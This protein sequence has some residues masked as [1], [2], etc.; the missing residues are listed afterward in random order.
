MP[1]SRYG[2]VLS[3]A[4]KRSMA[5]VKVYKFSSLVEAITLKDDYNFLNT[6][7]VYYPA[8]GEGLYDPFLGELYP[9]GG[10]YG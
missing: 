6:G 4:E 8:G 5:N 7:P 9:A 1:S 2:T 10:I 3:N